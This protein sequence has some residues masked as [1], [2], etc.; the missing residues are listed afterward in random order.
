MTLNQ[1]I[2]GLVGGR[3]P[4]LNVR[5]GPLSI[6]VPCPRVGD[7]VLVFARRGADCDVAVLPEWG[8]SGWAPPNRAVG[9]YPPA[10]Y[11]DRQS[12]TTPQPG[13]GAVLRPG[14]VQVVE[15]GAGLDFR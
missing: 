15:Q 1:R 3:V 4:P 7:G 11:A 8:Y 14:L 9:G 2:F 10:V 6:A 5:S 13:S 12:V